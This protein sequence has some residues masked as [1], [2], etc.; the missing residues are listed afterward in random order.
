MAP[1][2]PKPRISFLRDRNSTNE[3]DKTSVDTQTQTQTNTQLNTPNLN[4]DNNTKTNSFSSLSFNVIIVTTITV[5]AISWIIAF[6]GSIAASQEINYFPKLTWWGLVFELFVIIA[7]PV[8]YFLNLLYFY[9][10]FML[11]VIAIAFVYTTNSTNNLIYY[12]NSSCSAAGTGFILLSI[13]N[14]IW[15]FYL[16]SDQNAPLISTINKY[17]GSL[18]NPNRRRISS[19]NPR[20]NSYYPYTG[21]NTQSTTRLNNDPNIPD[22]EM[23]HPYNNDNIDL[24][25]TNGG[26]HELA[27]FEN[28]ATAT[29]LDVSNRI[30]NTLDY[31]DSAFR[32]SGVLIDMQGNTNTTYT[33][34]GHGTGTGTGT[35]TGTNTGTGISSATA[36]MEDYPIL[37][38]GLYDYV[39]SPDDVNE[40]SFAKG[41]LFRVKNT[42][43]NW[44]QGKNK[45]GEI[46]MCP[47]NYL[48]IVT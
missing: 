12:S 46:G 47:S 28:P 29:T 39:A 3:N 1:S 11:S 5:N 18:Q 43:G 16:G 19:L 17:G 21:L 42:N 25:S 27:G 41:E 32:A 24:Y 7:I 30:S 36:Y 26:A 4:N 37:V 9:K 8:L 38:R 23:S 15:L 20:A 45:R 14:F 22:L 35:N 33:G 6:A 34:T 10:N 2:I 40:L 48:E 44:W 31:S 13:A